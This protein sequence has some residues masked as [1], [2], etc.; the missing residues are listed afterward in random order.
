MPLSLAVYNKSLFFYR[1][2]L[3]CSFSKTTS[4]PA[5]KVFPINAAQVFTVALATQLPD[6]SSNTVWVACPVHL[7]DPS[8]LNRCHSVANSQRNLLVGHQ[9]ALVAIQAAITASPC[10]STPHPCILHQLDPFISTPAQLLTLDGT[11]PTIAKAIP[12][13][14]GIPISPFKR[15]SCTKPSSDSRSLSAS[16]PVQKEPFF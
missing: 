14:V 15:L 5:D 7:L 1:H 12:V 9:P 6:W 16:S 2:H 10:Q 3:P 13:F 8:V 11:I 4:G